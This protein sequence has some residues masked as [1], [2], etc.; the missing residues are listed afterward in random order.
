MTVPQGLRAGGIQ[1]GQHVFIIGA[2]GGV[3]ISAVEIAKHAG[4]QVTGVC[5]IRYL[6][7]MRRRGAEHV[8]GYAKQD[9]TLGVPPTTTWPFSWAGLILPAA[10]RKV[11]TH[12]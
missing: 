11:L 12:R 7:L 3:R 8:I 5:S 10:V 4:A 6:D 2:S 1:L 9:F